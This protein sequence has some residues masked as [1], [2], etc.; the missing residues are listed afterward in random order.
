[1]KDPCPN[2]DIHAPQRVICSNCGAPAKND[3]TLAITLM[4]ISIVVGY[5]IGISI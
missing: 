3:F 1:M 5:I 4:A 2:C